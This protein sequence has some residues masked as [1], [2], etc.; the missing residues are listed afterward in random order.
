MKW[1]RFARAVLALT[2]ALFVRLK[3]R[4]S[5]RALLMKERRE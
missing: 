5:R 2:I 4:F 3:L 1:R